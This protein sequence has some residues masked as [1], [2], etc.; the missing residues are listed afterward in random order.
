L[1]AVEGECHFPGLEPC[2]KQ[3][4]A[5]ATILKAVMAAIAFIVVTMG[6]AEAGHHG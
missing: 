5:R 1:V 3:K 2:P 4:E 6:E